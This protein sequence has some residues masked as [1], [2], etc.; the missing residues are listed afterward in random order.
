MYIL[1]CLATSVYSFWAGN[2][3]KFRGANNDDIPMLLVGLFFIIVLQM[4]SGLLGFLFSRIIRKIRGPVR[5]NQ[6][7]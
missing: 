3:T 4:F 1:L 2:V 5:R 7:H 6:P